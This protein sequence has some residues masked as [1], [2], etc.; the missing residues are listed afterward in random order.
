MTRR[1]LILPNNPGDVVMGLHAATALKN[2]YPHDA[3]AF[4]VDQECAALV[5]GNPSVDLCLQVP[6]KRIR[7]T[8]DSVQALAWVDGLIGSC[9]AF[10]PD[11]VINLFQ[12]DFAAI[13][14][15]QIVAHEY[16]GKIYDRHLHRIVV[17]DPWS[18]Y[19]HAIPAHRSTNDL[20]VVD[21]FLRICSVPASYPIRATLPAV[22]TEEQAR[23]PVI[24]HQ[25]PAIAIQAGSAW[26]GKQWPASHW[27]ELA[28]WFCQETAYSVV[29][30]GAPQEQ[31]LCATIAHGLPEDRI[32]NACGT[33]TLLSTRTLLSRCECLFCGDTF[34]MHA[35]S[36]LGVPVIALFGPSNPVETGPYQPGARILCARDPEGIGEQLDLRDGSWLQ[37]LPVSAVIATWQ[38]TFNTLANLE[39]PLL[40]QSFWNGSQLT[41]YNKCKQSQDSR[42]P[43]G[44]DLASFA[45]LALPHLQRL[46]AALDQWLETPLAHI[47]QSIEA[48]EQD[49]ARCT[50]NSLSFEMYRMELNGLA[51]ADMQTFV[52]ERRQLV[53]KMLS[54]CLE[55][56]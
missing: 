1:L 27:H 22:S 29:L 2:A 49:L 17:R 46:L 56:Q 40:I 28:R 11:V 6:R 15:A 39:S 55:G 24:Q 18:R 45:P 51:A 13:L 23:L 38:G 30:L 20:H 53:Q 31:N 37:S 5:E 50:H 26:I 35:A 34:A 48:H 7:E 33:T 36:A 52:R 10:A 44:V 14:A 43:E 32:I 8:T 9:N 21:I 16:R 19:L 42:L 41:L 25:R 3:L 4:V 54:L 47:A 12:G